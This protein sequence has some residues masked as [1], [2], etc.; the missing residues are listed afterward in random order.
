MPGSAVTI[1]GADGCLVENCFIVGMGGH[2]A[3]PPAISISTCTGAILIKNNQISEFGI[4]IF[5]IDA[6]TPIA[7]IG[8]YEANCTVGLY[9][10]SDGKYQGNITTNCV[11]PVTLA[12]AVGKENG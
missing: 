7:L 11:L 10:S 8:N 2:S 5:G 9:L 12:T 3:I 6:Y 4:A 1:S